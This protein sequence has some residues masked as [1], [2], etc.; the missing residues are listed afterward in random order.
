MLFL[1]G[2]DFSLRSGEEYQTQRM[3]HKVTKEVGSNKK[4]LA[5]QVTRN[6]NKE[7][8]VDVSLNY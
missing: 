8:R 7:I 2:F 5:K 6:I 4:K 1:C 3:H